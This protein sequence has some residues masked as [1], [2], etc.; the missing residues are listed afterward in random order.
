MTVL[1]ASVLG[2]G[3]VKSS[4]PARGPR[5]AGPTADRQENS[6]TQ[7]QASPIFSPAHRSF[8]DAV[9]DFFNWRPE[10]VQPIA[11][12]HRVHLASGMQCTICHV[13][14][15]TG[16][17][18]RIPGVAFCMTCHQAIAKDRPEVKK[19]AAFQARG[20]EIPWQRVY[21]YSAYAHVK[22]YHAPHVRAGV[23]CKVCHGDLKQQTVAVKSVDLNMGFCVDC[24]KQK[25]AS[26]DCMTCHF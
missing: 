14:V 4:S 10:P 22:F 19:M 21:V 18:A 7:P 15:D 6:S 3:L 12:T 26:I 5:G 25:K 13:G 23:G 1:I 20:E 24:H 8:A 2:W 9:K 16:P 17:D 11:Y